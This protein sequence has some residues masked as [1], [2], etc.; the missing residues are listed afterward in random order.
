M[1]IGA[2]SMNAEERITS[3]HQD[4]YTA[5]AFHRLLAVLNDNNIRSAIAR[6]ELS[7]A[8]VARY[9]E[10]LGREGFENRDSY[11]TRNYTVAVEAF[12]ADNDVLSA[13]KAAVF[14]ADAALHTRGPHAAIKFIKDAMSLLEETDDEVL[15]VRFRTCLA[16]TLGH[17]NDDQELRVYKRIII[18]TRDIESQPLQAVLHMFQAEARARHRAPARKTDESIEQGANLIV[19]CT[20]SEPFNDFLFACQMAKICAVR[21]E[22]GDPH[23]HLQHAVELSRAGGFPPGP[24]LA[25]RRFVH[26][27]NRRN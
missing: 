1:R 20:G 24:L 7:A 25:A 26:R 16:E 13:A 22:L 6:G 27:A 17:L 19:R 3:V 11:A 2:V 8:A 18:M 12:L 9:Y 4:L 15:Q 14:R 10:I 21:P 23:V 5:A